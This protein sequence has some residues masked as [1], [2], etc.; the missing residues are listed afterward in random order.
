[1]DFGTILGGLFMLFIAVM[2][3]SIPVFWI[4]RLVSG[5][6]ARL[7]TPPNHIRYGNIRDTSANISLKSEGYG[8]TVKWS[9]K[10]VASLMKTRGK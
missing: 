7:I 3:L 2:L 5:L 9:S 6:V 1:M 4:A 8:V 10:A